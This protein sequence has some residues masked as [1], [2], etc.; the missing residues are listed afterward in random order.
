MTQD[1]LFR[2]VAASVPALIS[3][4]GADYR[5][6]W[7]NRTY[8]TWFD[9]RSDEIV[10]R[11]VSDVLGEDAWEV[12]RPYMARA[13]AGED[14]TYE[15]EVPYRD[16]GPRWV[17]VTYVPDRDERGAVRGFVVLVTEI[18]EQKRAEQQVAALTDVL[19]ARVEELR[20]EHDDGHALVRVRDDGIGIPAESIAGVF[21]MF[22]QVD[23]E[24][25]QAVGGLG[26]GL[27]L[28]RRLVELHGGTVEAQSDGPGHGSLFTVRLPLAPAADEPVAQER[29]RPEQGGGLHLLVVDDNVDAA[30]TLAVLLRM[31][32][33]HVCVVFDGRAALADAERHRH[34]V[35]FLD[36]G[37]PE[38]DGYAVA[39]ALRAR[40]D[41]DGELLVAL[42]GWGEADA[43]RRSAEA[44]FDHHLVKPVQLEELQAVLASARESA[45][46]S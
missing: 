18:V 20:V 10:G 27:T 40:A 28:V 31:L 38:V 15:A 19:R 26:I 21:D 35:V 9:R 36:L 1:Q 44:G 13:L 4:I 16:I 32:G 29:A 14:V 24:A 34:D 39:R 41:A 17:R 2:A 5:Y 7:A 42:T 8:E 37:M 30:E 45:V 3:Y 22:A 12:V 25:R 23:R 6:R 43:R 33:H 46:R 11:P